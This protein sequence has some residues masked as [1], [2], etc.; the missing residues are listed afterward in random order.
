[1]ELVNQ[2]SLK[3]TSSKKVIVTNVVILLALLIISGFN[4]LIS[5]LYL[6]I[7]FS[8]KISGVL[9]SKKIVDSKIFLSVISVFFYVM[10]LQCVI[11]ISWIIYKDFSLMLDIPV[12]LVLLAIFYIIIKK[13]NINH[14]A[15]LSKIN[16]ADILSIIVV[17]VSI[18]IIVYIP[19]HKTDINKESSLFGLIT[20]AVDDSSHIGL[21]NDRIQFD[22]GVILNSIADGKT[23]SDGA[24]S[25]PA[26]WHSANA[27]IIKSFYPNIKTGIETI[28]SYTITKVFWFMLLV[29]VF[30]RTIFSLY[31][32]FNKRNTSAAVSFWIFCSSILFTCWFLSSPFFEGFYSFIPQLIIIPI[33]LLTLI[34]ISLPEKE[35]GVNLANS[36]FLPTL[37]CVGSALSWLL[38][39]PVFL[40]TLII[41]VFD[42][43]FKIGARRFLK[44]LS[45]NM[46]RLLFFYLVIIGSVIVQTYILSNSGLP[47]SFIQ[48]ILLTGGIILYP[49]SFYGF[50]LFGIL[51]LLI[52]GIKKENNRLIKPV[53]NYI[54]AILFFTGFLYVIQLYK[55]QNN[56]YYYFKALDTFTIVGAMLCIIGF[57][58]IIDL[59]Q[60]KTTK[61]FAIGL[62]LTIALISL[63]F[64]YPKPVLFAYVSGAKPLSSKTDEQILNILK[65]NYT[66]TNYYNK[67][68]AI[69]YPDNNLVVNEV[70]SMLLKSNKQNSS[71]FNIL[72]ADSF[73]TPP[74]QFNAN[75]I[76]NNCKDNNIRITY[77]VRKNNVEHLQNVINQSKLEDKVK[78]KVIDY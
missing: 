12:T 46:P 27:A 55:T 50:I 7:L 16:S 74:T 67:E 9:I 4:I 33:F 5:V 52:F 44:E 40:L 56:F 45:S 60:S 14:T 63:Q 24:A 26:G 69:F 37:L 58:I 23:R 10:F 13:N 32:I 6:S 38:L 41:C 28:I 25:Y 1:M 36:F 64:V 54:L 2:I 53:F 15:L 35:S 17:L 21:M 34:Q 68:V 49:E 65:T 66:Q 3:F 73:T 71:C 22:R 77:Y 31:K 8:Y 72:K 47:V 61:I 20:N 57:S 75:I 70:G 48:G 29:F 51:I 76:N 18:F 39:F 59:V 11:L 78:I 62:S 19:I 43:S 42:K 30:V